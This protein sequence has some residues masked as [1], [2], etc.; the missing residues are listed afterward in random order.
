MPVQTKISVGFYRLSF[1]G[2]TTP[3]WNFATKKDNIPFSLNCTQMTIARIVNKI[4]LIC[5]C[6]TALAGSGIAQRPGSSTP[7]Q[8]KLLNGLKILA[9][10]DPA[11]EKATVKIRFHGGSSFDPQGREG[12]MQMLSDS[13]FQTAEA[14]EFFT[15]ELGGSL[16]VVCNYD[17][18]QI[19][20][21]SRPAEFLTMLETIATAV[22]NPTLDKEASDALK[23]ALT[24]RVKELE[25]DPAYMAD[26][27]VAKRLFGS[28]PYGR[29]QMGT[30]DSIQ[31]IDFADLR[32]AKDRLLTADNAT[33]AVSGNV[34]PT[35]ALRAVRRYFGSWLK[36]DKKV[37]STFKQPDAPVAGLPVVNSPVPNTSEFRFAARGLA[38]NDS[39]FYASKI[40][41]KIVENRLRSREGQKSFVRSD[42]HVLPGA[43]VFGVSDW[44][45]GRI[46]KEGN[47]IA[48]P[49]TDGYQNNFIKGPVT[50]E[51]FDAVNQQWIAGMNANNLSELWL[52]A[53][54]FR[55]AAV[56]K[57]IENAK[58]V[59]IGDVQRVLDKLQK[60][61]FAFVLVFAGETTAAPGN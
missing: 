58:S 30:V 33:V 6:T 54:T 32:F 3:G 40:L 52:D 59:K 35:L 39:D 31:K 20:A 37:P 27:A 21:S 57:E 8:E 2:V 23:A 24:A 60:E 14:R 36:S 45:L 51:E 28:F 48:L 9:W 50:Q 7:R 1:A 5:L 17:Y 55:L 25:K 34:D 46:R 56:T 42:P 38:R 41:Q 43:Y 29:P 4:G 44:N 11:A 49:V 26:Q 12:V 47:T 53:D 10:S 16:E 13:F 19:N 22:A 61:P 18:I 15:D